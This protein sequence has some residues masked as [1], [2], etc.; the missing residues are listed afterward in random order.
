MIHKLGVVGHPVKHSLSP[1]IHRAFA[2]QA[3]LEIIYDKYD[4]ED[5]ELGLFIKE[6]FANGG[7]GLNITIPHK[8]NCIKYV[9]T[10]AT[11]VKRFMSANT[12]ITKAV[13]YTHL[14]LPTTP[15]L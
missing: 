10:A 12:L 1:K 3:G 5:A 9:D 8:L 7:K 14:T 2:R 11:A 15:Y 6:F 4:I 13:S